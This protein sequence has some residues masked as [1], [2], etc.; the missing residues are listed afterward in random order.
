MATTAQGLAAYLVVGLALV[1]ASPV[2]AD[3]PKTI[4]LRVHNFCGIEL[5]SLE[6]AQRQ[7]S[8]IYEAIGVSLVWVNDDPHTPDEFTGS[9]PFQVALL[10]RAATEK[11]RLPKA[12]LGVAPLSHDRVYAF[13]ERITKLSARERV[14]VATT[15]GRVLAHEVGHLV[16]PGKGHSETGIMR[17]IPDYK[18]KQAPGFT[19][20]QAASIHM[21]LMAA[22]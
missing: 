22:R 7:A 6:E 11:L 21:R 3:E 18:S 5:D 10:S 1:A 13:C 19:D 15:L 12:V 8:R 14:S 4:V 2:T 16:L 9:A 17:A 20:D